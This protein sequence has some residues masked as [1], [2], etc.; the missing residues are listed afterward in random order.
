MANYTSV[1]ASNICDAAGNKLASGN[2]SFQATDAA[3]QPLNFQVGGGGQVVTTPATATITAGV[4]AGGFQV[5]D[6]ANTSP[7][8]ILY[9][10]TIAD[11]TLNRVV[12]TYSLVT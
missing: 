7:A 11:T 6:S 3:N 10:I 4:I 1:I 9:R 5:A 2:V 12:A 8:G